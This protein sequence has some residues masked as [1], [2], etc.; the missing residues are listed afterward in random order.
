MEF[1]FPAEMAS[2]LVR[3]RA[4]APGHFEALR[5]VAADPSIWAQHPERRDQPD[6]FARYFQSLMSGGAYLIL[7]ARTEA[8]L[9]CTSYIDYEPALG[10]V[11]IGSTFLARRYWGGPH[12]RA[13]MSLLLRHAETYATHAVFLV[14]PDNERSQRSLEKLG[15]VRAGVRPNGD[16]DENALYRLPTADWRR[17][18]FDGQPTVRGNWV[19][20]Q[21]LR[22]SDFEALFAAAADPLIWDQHPAE[23]WREPVFREFFAH[24]M[25]SGGA[26]LALDA[27][28]GEVIGCSRYHRFRPEMGEIEIGYTF[29][30]RSH[31]G[32]RYNGE[33]KALML[34]HAFQY[35]DAV[36][37]LVAPQNL[38]SQR[39]VEKL[40]AARVGTVPH[41]SGLDH[42]RFRLTADAFE[43]SPA[44]P[45]CP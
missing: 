1:S 5:A 2:R 7:D 14:D 33:M 8:V 21:P 38:R 34:R 16:G 42:I 26:L 45:T 13:V 31:W 32:G 41:S 18:A 23:R 43:G 30:K 35:V 11:E 37:F 9:G 6:V 40:G 24:A 4:L 20:L 28:S 10:E 36:C 19:Q 17:L 27:A 44:A 39:A 25:D 29:L 3:L 22:D 15:A 12:R